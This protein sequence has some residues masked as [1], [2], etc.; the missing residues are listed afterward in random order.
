MAAAVAFAESGSVESAAPISSTHTYAALCS[1]DPT[2]AE[3]DASADDSVH[4][5]IHRPCQ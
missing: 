1:S 4:G 3:H 5:L 2:C